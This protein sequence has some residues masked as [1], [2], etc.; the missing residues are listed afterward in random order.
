MAEYIIGYHMTNKFI[1]RPGDNWRW[2]FDKK[3]DCLMLEISHDMVFRSRFS[4]KTLAPD[5]FKSTRFS[6]N[7]TSAYY[8]FYESCMG[9]N[10]S[11][12]Q[13]VE[14]ILNAIVARNFL[15]PQMPKSWY[16]VQQPM[17]FTPRFAE[18]IEAQVQDSGQRINLLVVEIGEYASLCL[19][20]ETSV[21]MAGKQFNMADAVKVMN[22]RL[23]SKNPVVDNSQDPE[24]EEQ[25]IR[26]LLYQFCS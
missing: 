8:H 25:T 21:C 10:L 11:E 18:L 22:D 13:K 24:D 19:I 5:A 12:P 26:D 23:C 20:A 16:F 4:S 1:V 9:L 7:D 15:K 14:L 2:Y 6:V 3:Y 17:Q